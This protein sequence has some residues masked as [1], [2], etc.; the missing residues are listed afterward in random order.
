MRILLLSTY[1]GWG[2][3]AIAT[4]RLLDALT[5]Y[6]IKAK[7]LVRKKS[8][9]KITVVGLEKNWL[10][11]WDFVWERTVIWLANRFSKNNIYALDIANTG[12]DITSLPEFKQADVI[13]LHWVNQGMLSLKNI[14]KIMESGKKIVWTMHD[15]WPATGICH[16]T[17]GCDN[18]HTECRNCSFLT[19][20]GN[21]RDLS[22]RTFQK[23]MKIYKDSSI[24]FVSCSQ[25]LAEK[26]GKSALMDGH[27]VTCIPNPI[28]TNLFRPR[29]KKQAREKYGLPQDKKL[30]LFSAVKIT[31]QRKGFD[32]LIQSCK[33]LAHKHPETV[34]NTEIVILG[35]RSEQLNEQLAPFKVHT[36]GFIGKE[37]D[38]VDV[39]NAVDLY[40]TPSLQDNLPNTI[41]EA[42]ACGIPCVGFNVGG[43]PE[44]IDHIHN[45]YVAQ[46]KSSED[47]ANGI[48]WILTESDYPTLAEQAHR[49]VITSYSESTIAR[50]YLDVYNKVTMKHA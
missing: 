46:Y 5:N 3:P 25:W 27:E 17:N 43:I 20:G 1:D 45:G 21:K 37:Q 11:V 12:I 28:N 50:K 9:D 36:L 29:N 26:A 18:Y 41:M 14:R 31:D 42:M 2:G 40:V 38:L 49:K 33:L 24:T 35:K 6:G 10:Y 15:M 8:V 19:G 22:Y 16:Y 34:E 7:A 30:I 4:V 48:Y 44:M 47:F 23:K 32:Y 13:H 39:Y